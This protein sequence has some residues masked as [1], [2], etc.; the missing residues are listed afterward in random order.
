VEKMTAAKIFKATK[1]FFVI[2]ALAYLV[3]T[4]IML[5]G[6]ILGLMLCLLIATANEAV[7]M[8]FG[9]I[10]MG[11]FF[12]FLQL[13]KRYVLYM[14]KA[15][16]I[17]AIT[18]YIKT[19]NVPVTEGGYKGVVAYGTE[20]VKNNFG[21]ANVAF[22]ADS[23]IRG[24]TRQIMKW[25]NRI[26]NLFSWIPGGKNVM[27]FI[28]FV[29]S[30]ALNFIDEAIL[31]YIFFNKDKEGNGFKKACDGL[32][33]YA[34]SWKAMLKGAL[35]VGVFVWV[36]RVIVYVTFFALFGLVGRLIVAGSGAWLIAFILAFIILYGVEAVLV[37]PYST[38]I[39]LNDYHKAIAGQPLKSDIHGKLCKVSKKFKDL[40]GK[41]EQ[42]LPA[43]P[44]TA[45]T[46]L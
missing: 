40:F 43:E 21:S 5:V 2:R 44:T 36:L 23:L 42:P 34:Q 6:G 10:L 29:L 17:A 32:G 14:I 11:G 24:A 16:H 26:G 38:C 41:S 46:E 8:F 28:E 37:D 4:L 18:E 45:P 13:A 35:K 30:T 15:A 19:G 31:S 25:V 27:A 12:G 33:Y 39:M 9:I 7:G 20:M 22:V 1:P 3:V